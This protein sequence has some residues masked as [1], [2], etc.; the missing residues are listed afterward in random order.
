MKKI[1]AL[2]HSCLNTKTNTFTSLL[3]IR[4]N[5]QRKKKKKKRKKKEDTEWGYRITTFLNGSNL[6]EEVPFLFLKYII[7]CLKSK[8]QCL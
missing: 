5:Y 6:F 1:R 2:Y 3:P 8:I 7:T 4:N